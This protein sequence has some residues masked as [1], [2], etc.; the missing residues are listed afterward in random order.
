[1]T[2]ETYF[3][4]ANTEVDGMGIVH[5]S[6]YPLWF[7]KG[8]KDFM[9]KAGL[10]NS[11]IAGKGFFLPLTELECKYKSPAKYGCEIIVNTKI[12]S[13]SCVKI[14]YEYEVLDRKNGNILAKG[15]TVHVWTNRRIEPVNIE[16]AA[17]EIYRRL[18]HFSES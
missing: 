12:L 9:K 17:P 4:V 18:K 15:R 10:S 7:E 11:H 13:M 6:V 2:T 14:K 8:R 1:M 16:K 5:H 3:P